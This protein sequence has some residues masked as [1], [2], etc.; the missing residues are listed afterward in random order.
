M[1]SARD[2]PART[3]KLKGPLHQHPTPDKAVE[4]QAKTIHKD[5][6][7]RLSSNV[8]VPNWRPGEVA[9]LLGTSPPLSPWI[10]MKGGRRLLMVGS[11]FLS[12]S[13]RHGIFLLPLELNILGWR[14]FNKQKPRLLVTMVATS[15]SSSRNGICA[16]MNAP[17]NL[18]LSHEGLSKG[19]CCLLTRRWCATSWRCIRGEATL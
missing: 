13:P 18:R 1:V 17:S 6:R 9:N 16:R 3:Q 11:M 7:P 10:W 4:R 12:W 19:C 8:E 15:G 5:I 14:V 2:D